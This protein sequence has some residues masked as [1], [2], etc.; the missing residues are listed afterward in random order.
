MTWVF[1]LSGSFIAAIIGAHYTLLGTL[2]GFSFG[3]LLSSSSR[4]KKL[5]SH[6][7]ELQLQINQLQKKP[8]KSDNNIAEPASNTSDDVKEIPPKK[9]S[10]LKPQSEIR[11]SL[12]VDESKEVEK[13]AT[14]DPWFSETQKP[15]KPELES[16]P[17]PE[18]TEDKAPEF[19]PAFKEIEPSAADKLFSFIWRWF[20][21][22]NT[23]VRVGIVILFIGVSFLLNL[24]I[25][26]NLISIELRLAAVTAF[27]IFLLSIGWRLREK[28]EHYALLIQGGA[29]GLLYLTI[30]ASF[31]LYDVLPSSVAFVFLILIVILS[32]MLAILQNALS[33]VLFGVIGGFLAPILTSTGSNNYI[34]L[35]SFYTL[36]N[37][38]IFAIA[39]FRAWKIL[40]LVGFTFTFS[41]SAFWG[42]S[43]YHPDNFSTIEPF[44]ILFFLFYVGIAILYATR[45]SVDF[46]DYVDGTLIFGTPI[47]AFG[48][49]ASIV[50]HYQYGIAISAF[51]MGGFYL[52]IAYGCW[53]T[54]GEK[55]RFLSETLLAVAVIFATLAIPFAVG[56][57]TTSAA[58]A[59]EAT[60]V[61]WVSIRQGQHFRRVFAL[62]LQF[63]AGLALLFDSTVYQP[64]AFL[65]SSFMGVLIITVCAGLSSWM[66]YQPFED[67]REY[68]KNLSSWIFIYGLFWLFGGYEYQI[69]THKTLIGYHDKLI[70]FL[71]LLTNALLTK[72]SL[73][74]SWTTANKAALWMLLPL[75]I[76]AFAIVSE[77]SH[78]WKDYGFLLWTL[79]LGIYFFT[80]KTSK[81]LKDS[82][83]LNLHL[84]T[85]LLIHCLL[86]QEGT[87]NLLRGAS[88][89]SLLFYYLYQR[90]QWKQMSANALFLLPVM[91]FLTVN[92]LFSNNAHPF[93]LSDSFIGLNTI[94]GGYFLWTFAFFSL[95]FLYHQFDKRVEN[96]NILPTFYALALLLL[97]VLITWESAWHFTLNVPYLN[98]WHI[99]LF[100]I[101]S[102][103]ALWLIMDKKIASFKRHDEA[104][105]KIASPVF[106]LYLLIWT[107]SNFNAEASA[108]PLPWL[109]FANPA[110]LLQ[111]IVFITLIRFT[112]VCPEKYL[113]TTTKRSVYISLSLLIF[114]WLNFVLLRTLHYWGG[115]SWSASLWN[116]AIT[117]TCLSIFWTLTGLGFALFATHKQKRSLWIVGSVLLGIVVIKLLLFDMSSH[118]SIERIISFIGVGVLLMAIGYF[119]PLPPAKK[120]E[121]DAEI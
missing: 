29:V 61:L 8:H 106:I 58:W 23:F 38:G 114:I 82:T 11:R 94:E 103:A 3:L 64:Q 21:D 95:Y 121:Q 86:F 110:E 90:Y 120:D 88:L 78:P 5:E 35:F 22:G 116:Q 54:L 53:K 118:N 10:Y 46:K 51:V 84:L 32:A 19:K 25:E 30:F 34:G 20:T 26:N 96:L 28:R 2:L 4:I 63:L 104:Y 107:I 13:K 112:F 44:L 45:R 109:P 49:Q 102:I 39:W 100:P 52:A 17:V 47:I 77:N 40:N 66:L 91:L 55:L 7:T 31:S 56:G 99:A 37:A 41:I 105:F 59:V 113:S 117:Q 50:H 42:A 9:I 75:F 80:L 67:R 15:I 14:D 87:S 24:A 89:L 83:N 85:T 115:L 98:G 79:A 81:S 12:I 6:L 70:L 27:A 18:S 48:M 74:L 71:T 62:L 97:A 57:A 65:N 1:A 33:L 60:G 16:E 119:T 73:R 111:I 76:V 108:Q 69:D 68:E 93:D 36:L 101:T 92:I 43:S 72:L